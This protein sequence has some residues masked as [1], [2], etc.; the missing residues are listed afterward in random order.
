MLPN[1]RKLHLKVVGNTKNRGVL[2]D[3]EM[4]PGWS[5]HSSIMAPE[6]N[7]KCSQKQSETTATPTPIL[8]AHRNNEKQQRPQTLSC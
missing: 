8:S 5:T 7:L 2:A 3:Q 6:I 4:G 1:T